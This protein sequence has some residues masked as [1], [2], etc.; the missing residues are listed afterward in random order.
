M[1]TVK[2]KTIR[3]IP[4]ERTPMREQ[5]PKERARN[6]KEVALGYALPEALNEAERCL[7]CADAPCVRGCPAHGFICRLRP[8]SVARSAFSG[9][10]AAAI[11]IRSS[12]RPTTP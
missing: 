7:M 1:A 11:P 2:K 4:Q 8:T 3:T 5:D 10:K 12:L 6:F 9:R